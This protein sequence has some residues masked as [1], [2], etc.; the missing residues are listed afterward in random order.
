MRFMDDLHGKEQKVVELRCRDGKTFV[1]VNDY[2]ALRKL[3]GQLLT[4]VQ[5]IKSEGDYK[6]GRDLVENYGVRFDTKLHAE[7]LERYASLNLYPFKG[8][9]NPVY[10]LVKDVDGKVTDIA[11]TY[12]EG[13]AEQML[14]YSHNYSYLNCFDL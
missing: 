14:R 10:Q 1:V 3:F 11:V 8:F 7:V 6:A 13:Y 12:T 4:E 9:I 5:R 2:E